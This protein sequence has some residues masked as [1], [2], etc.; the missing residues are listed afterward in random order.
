L[1]VFS[2]SCVSASGFETDYVFVAGADGVDTYRIPSI[3]VASDG[4]LLVF[5]E[6]RKVSIAD[7]SPTDMV[8][9]RSMDGGRTWQPMQTLVAGTGAEA[10]M[11]PCPVIDR[12]R[13]TI[14]LFCINANKH[15]ENHHGHMIL[16]SSDNGKTWSHPVDI[17]PMIRRYENTFVSGPGIGI[18][19]KNGRLVIPGYAGDFDENTKSG[20]YSRALFS[21]DHGATWTLGARTAEFS[22]ESQAIELKDGTLMLNMRGDMGTGCRGVAKSLDGGETWAEFGWDRALNEC[23]CQASIVRYGFA[24]KDGKDR[25]LFSNPDNYGETFGRVDRAKMTVRMSYDEGKTWP[26]KKL[27]HAGPSSYS[28]LA[29]LPDGDIGIVYEGGE[30]HR[31][32]WIRFARFSIEWLTDGKDQ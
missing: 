28:V 7:A 3:I 20:F 30:K 2:A 4:S 16:R 29:R 8:L 12:S 13:G 18:Q 32:E 27:I 21:D 25:I 22:D 9:R 10:L 11:N 31:R 6:A 19:L 26:V 23:P 17:A 14:I 15:G 24:E 5:A 1:C